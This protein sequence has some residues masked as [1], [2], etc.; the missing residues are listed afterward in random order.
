MAAVCVRVCLWQLERAVGSR[1]ATVAKI[2]DNC[3]GISSN[4]PEEEPPRRRPK[5]IH[6]DSSAEIMGHK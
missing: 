4:A 3:V 6:I 5:V 1:A 2:G